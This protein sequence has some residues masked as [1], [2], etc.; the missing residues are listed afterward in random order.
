MGLSSISKGMS[1]SIQSSTL[2]LGVWLTSYSWHQDIKPD[3]I[4]IVRKPGA[5]VWDCHFKLA[6]LGLSHFHKAAEGGVDTWGA[7]AQGTRDYGRRVFHNLL[8][9]N[10]Y[11]TLAAPEAYRSGAFAMKMPRLISP[12]ADVWSLGCVF[13]EA[14]AWLFDGSKGVKEYRMA[15][16]RETERLSPAFTAKQ[17]FHD[18]GQRGDKPQVCPSLV[19]VAQLSLTQDAAI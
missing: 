18:A 15:R 13:S 14:A 2:D 19:M 5:P 10:A 8:Q 7:D 6:D 1:S 4:L 3:N 11:S 12:N 16:Y 9:M 17:G